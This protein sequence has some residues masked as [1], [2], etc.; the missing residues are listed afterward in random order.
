MAH[1]YRFAHHSHDMHLPWQQLAP[2]ARVMA[3]LAAA[4]MAFALLQ[5]PP[6]AAAIHP[7]LFDYPDD[8]SDRLA[9]P[10]AALAL[11]LAPE[12]KWLA[13]D[14]GRTGI[15]IELPWKWREAAQSAAHERE[16]T[17]SPGWTFSR[18][19]DCSV[20][21]C[22]ASMRVIISG[23]L[24][25]AGTNIHNSA[26]LERQMPRREVAR[27]VA[28]IA[29]VAFID[30]AKLTPI[31]RGAGFG[32]RLGVSRQQHGGSANAIAIEIDCL[33]GAGKFVILTAVSDADREETAKAALDEIAQGISALAVAGT[34]AT[35][36]TSAN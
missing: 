32:Y 23:G 19:Y 21:A 2:V 26:D 14:D 10:T 6:A 18:L 36:S 12:P 25:P 13:V 33:Y 31:S 15:T 28:L 11:S 34:S 8:A 9:P 24:L 1:L 20:A 27:I 35:S 29:G 30:P 3:A 17:K 7:A 4:L 5:T 22:G 16:V